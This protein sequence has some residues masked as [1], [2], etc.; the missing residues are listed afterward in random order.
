MKQKKLELNLYYY[1]YN[2]K[3]KKNMDLK[4]NLERPIIYGIILLAIYGGV[5]LVMD[6][7][8]WIC[9]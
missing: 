4:N 2:T 7:V 1:Y 6:I 8:K 3:I 9:F 5:R